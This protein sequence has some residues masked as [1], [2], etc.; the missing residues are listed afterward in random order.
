MF[1]ELSVSATMADAPEAVF[2]ASKYDALVSDGSTTG[3]YT[4]VF[5]Y[6]DMHTSKF[7]TDP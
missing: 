1:G 5:V 2:A 4:V 7:K 6:V 3:D